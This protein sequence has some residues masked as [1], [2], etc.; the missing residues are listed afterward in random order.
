MTTAMISILASCGGGSILTCTTC[1]MGP[2]PCRVC[3]ADGDTSKPSDP[4]CPRCG[5]DGC[6]PEVRDDCHTLAA[7]TGEA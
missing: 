6:D 2:C 3:L 1:W 5:G 7:L 4:D